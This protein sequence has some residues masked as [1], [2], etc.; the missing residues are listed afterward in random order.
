MIYSFENLQ[1]SSILEAEEHD[2]ELEDVY[3]EDSGN[4]EELDIAGMSY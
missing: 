3:G 2:K 1:L 4:P